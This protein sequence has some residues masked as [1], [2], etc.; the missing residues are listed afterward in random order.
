MFRTKTEI[1]STP[2]EE[3]LEVETPE[4]QHVTNIEFIKVA[5]TTEAFGYGSLVDY[6]GNEYEYEWDFK[7]K[8]II[9]LSGHRV[10][11][12][13][14]DLCE[15]VLQKYYVKNDK[16]VE[17]PVSVQVEKSLSKALDPI[18]TSFKNI[19]G[20]LDKALTPKPAPASAPVQDQNRSVQQIVRPAAPVDVPAVNVADDDISVN[21]LRFLQE[22]HEDD[23]GIDYMSL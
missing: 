13:I 12:L 23:L 16:A 2:V 1:I 20:K 15:K 19:E 17:E 21:A 3:V 18:T 4:T 10:D 5:G 14:W 6:D 22:N 8:R 7:S 9:H 11:S